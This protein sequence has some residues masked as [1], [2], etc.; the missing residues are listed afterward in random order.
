MIA[1][2]M[3]DKNLYLIHDYYLVAVSPAIAMVQGVLVAYLLKPLA[4][5]AVRLKERNV[6]CQF[7]GR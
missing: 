5:P 6:S 4:R 1:A 7:R 3:I 2:V